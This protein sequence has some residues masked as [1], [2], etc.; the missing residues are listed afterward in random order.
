MVNIKTQEFLDHEEKKKHGDILFPFTK[1][2]T[3]IPDFYT[4]FPV[5]WHEEIEIVLVRKGKCIFNINSD[6]I[7][8]ENGD[9]LII[10]PSALHS[11]RQYE[12]YTYCSDTYIFN[13]SLINN[14][15]DICNSKYFNPLLNNKCNP[16]YILKSNEKFNNKLLMLLQDINELYSSKKPC[17]E[18][19]IKSRLLELFSILFENNIIKVN[20]ETKENASISIIKNIIKYI[21]ENY[22]ENITLESLSHIFKIS[23]YHLAH[24]FK[25]ITEVSCKDFIINYRLNISAEK[26]RNTNDSI[27]NIALNNGFNNISYFN[28]AF[29][30]KFK[31]TPTEY[32][33]YHKTS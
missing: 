6:T 5:H 33:K 1:Y 25:D 2:F 31:L 17:Y 27:L 24:L 26:I 10:C 9:I 18:L 23:V 4:S 13:L 30:K 8:V 3:I 19:K 28:R 16:Y 11:F 32:R 7:I 21:E 15:I 29:K 22:R 20:K 12:D 14:S